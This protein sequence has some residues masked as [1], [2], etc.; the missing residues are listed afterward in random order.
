MSR[1]ATP[2]DLIPEA[3]CVLGT[4][5]RPFSLGHHLLLTRL[6]LPYAGDPDAEATSEILALAVF[7]CAARY[8][9]TQEAILRGEW[10]AAHAR[11]TKK[12]KG[13]FYHRPKFVH[14]RELKKF[15]AYLAD[16]Y[17]TAPV[18]RH[19]SA[20]GVQLTAPWECLLQV[21]LI[22]AGLGRLETLE[23]YLPAAWY[24]YHTAAELDQADDPNMTPARWRKVF[25]TTEDEAR[26][27]AVP[28]SP[29]ISQSHADSESDLGTSPPS[30]LRGTS[31]PAGNPS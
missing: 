26:Y 4:L 9:E 30:P 14:E 6:E 8:S 11:W 27:R 7:I 10:S 25:W 2:R 5:L 1:T 23:L 17:R 24:H 15:A 16:G 20:G 13:R 21:R 18:C 19:Q 12:L 28:N 22:A 29:Q 3:H 31:L